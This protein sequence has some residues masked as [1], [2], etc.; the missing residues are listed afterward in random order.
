MS[1]LAYAVAFK[2]VKE[3]LI[4]DEIFAVGDAGFRARCERRYRELR[5][6]GHTIVV[7]SHDPRVVQAFCDRALLLS[8]GRIAVEGAVHDVVEQYTSMVTVPPTS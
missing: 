5:A 4:L 8:D 6:L 3:I 7:V 2:A 1:R